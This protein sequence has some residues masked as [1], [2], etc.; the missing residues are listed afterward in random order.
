M[1]LTG[2]ALVCPPGI[3]PLQEYFQGKGA[4]TNLGNI[5]IERGNGTENVLAA[6]GQFVADL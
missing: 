3:L 5:C 4:E 6:R 2:Q 1:A